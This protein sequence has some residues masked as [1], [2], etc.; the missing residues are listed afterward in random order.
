MNDAEHTYTPP[1]SAG[2]KKLPDQMV[3]Y[4]DGTDLLRK[5]QALRIST[6]DA[7][8][9]PHAALLSAGDMLVVSPQRLRFAVFAESVT[10]ANVA[11]D[12]RVTLT[13]SLDRGMCEV[14]MHAKRLSKTSND[15]ALAFFEGTVEDVRMHVA[16]YADVTTGIT[17]QLHEPYAVRGRWERQM[18]AL[19][20][21]S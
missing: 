17:F 12:S 3:R 1:Q 7:A 13:L 14:R 8:G 5:T 19:K 16:P 21:A 11:R 2:A 18:T 9:W 4:L 6:V 20:N 10:A 15:A